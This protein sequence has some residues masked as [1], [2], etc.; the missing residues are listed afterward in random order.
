MADPVLSC[1]S[2]SKTYRTSAG[3]VTA[4]SEITLDILPGEMTAIIGPSGSGKTT[5]LSMLGGLERPS[6]GE[7]LVEGA[8]L[9]RRFSDLSDYRRVEVGFVFQAYNLLP[10]LTALENV[11]LPM[12]LAGA[13]RGQRRPRAAELL[14]AVGIP[15]ERY[16]H[17]PLRLS[18]GEQQ[19][20]AVARALAN[21][22]PILLAD[23]PTGNLDGETSRQV[24]DLI[25]GMAKKMG[26]CVVV[27]THNPAI[28]QSADRV[29]KL[30]YG[31]IESDDRNGSRVR[32][33]RAP[34][35]VLRV[36][37]D[38]PLE[39]AEAAHAA[40]VKRL[41]PDAAEEA[42]R[43]LDEALEELRRRAAGS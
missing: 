8:P 18:G 15:P 3:P 31:R 20:V 32:L 36:A 37:P 7:I 17:R 29:V 22:P 40:L 2:L 28:A 25:R 42:T 13:P 41:G 12:E 11:L 1:R 5:L 38:A 33:R 23:E 30:N 27:V 21:H 14:T 24:I 43:E 19:R 4:I 6:E 16:H 39:I 35:E 26:I 34:Y 9:E 10:H